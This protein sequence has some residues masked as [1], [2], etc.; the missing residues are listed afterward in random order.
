MASPVVAGMHSVSKRGVGRLLLREDSLVVAVS[1]VC[2]AAASEDS[3]VV[4]IQE[5]ISSK[6]LMSVLAGSLPPGI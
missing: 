4:S 2:G 5:S 3:L 6:S 1:D